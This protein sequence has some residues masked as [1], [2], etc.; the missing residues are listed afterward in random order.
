ML[1]LTNLYADNLPQTV[2]QTAVTAVTHP[3]LI[4]YSAD[5]AQLLGFESSF[6]NTPQAASLLSG[7]QLFNGSR[8]VAQKYAG[9]QFGSYNPELGDG[10]GLLLGDIIAKDNMRYEL[11]LK[12]AGRTA[13]SRFGDG[14]AVLRSSIREFLCSEAMYHLGI[15]T[16]RALSLIGSDEPVQREQL[17]TAAMIIRVCQ[18]HIRFGHFENY[19]YLKQTD[20]LKQ[21]INFSI[22]HYFPHCKESHNPIQAFLM[23]VVQR[24]ARLIA[25]WQAV[26]FA[27]GVMN[28]DN[29]SI[30]GITFDYGPFAFMDT[31]QPGLISN[32]SDHSGRYAFDEQPSVAL[33]NLNALG[34][35]LSP[36][37]SKDDISTALAQYEPTLISHYLQLMR[38]KLGLFTAQPEDRQLI[39]HWLAILQQQQLDYTLSFRYLSELGNTA[40]NSTL[41]DSMK[42][43]TAYDQWQQLYR[44]RLTQE[45]LSETQRHALMKQR[46]PIYILRNYLAQQVIEAAEQGDYQPLQ[47]LQQVLRQ[48]YT[49]QTGKSAFAAPPPDWGKTLVISCSS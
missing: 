3:R 16:S 12:G 24:T 30:L 41:R 32:H 18:S 4:S 38:E 5:L 22:E 14:R 21:L 20:T 46:N 44:Q 19:F 7:A 26:G 10:R 28:T 37:I 9:H 2:R 13:Y 34:H 47:Q 40:E 11:H 1:T 31:Y 48:P 29:M 15:P 49:E 27:H 42:D 39:G 36:F 23:E 8:P 35:T 45:V 17:E 43:P 6:F 33:W 25:Q